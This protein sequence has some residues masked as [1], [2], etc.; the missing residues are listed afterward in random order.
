MPDSFAQ[1]PSRPIHVMH[2]V[3]R[4][5]AGGGMENGIINVANRLPLDR[6]KISICALDSEETFSKAIKRSDSE[7]HLLPK[8][9]SGIDWSLVTRLSKLFKERKVD[10]VHSH[11]WGTFIYSVLGAKLAHV[12]IIHGEHGKNP[13]EMGRESSVRR[14]TKSQ[15]GRRLDLLTTVSQTLADEWAKEY[16][17]PA[18]KIQW[19]PNGVDSVRFSPETDKTQFRVNLGLP[20]SA[21]VVGTVGRMDSLKNV[22]VLIAAFAQLAAKIPEAYL[23]LVGTGPSESTL[24]KQAE[25]SGFADRIKFLGHRS[26]TPDVFAAM[27]VFVLPSKFEGMSNVLL[28]AMASGLAVVCADLP[29]HREVFVPDVEGILVSPCEAQNLSNALAKLVVQPEQRARLGAAARA[30]ILK[31]F[32]LM[33]MTRAYERA[34]LG[35]LRSN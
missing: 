10:V 27:D 11:N 2:V 8:N 26:D 7:F 13:D 31:D 21:S 34:Y 9:G 5:F 17:V 3:R 1:P 15:L 20:G 28:E 30:R 16:R 4:G 32:D 33:R 24:R 12:P 6:F 25:E 19:I 14:F 29:A 18:E 23:L 22:E 35:A